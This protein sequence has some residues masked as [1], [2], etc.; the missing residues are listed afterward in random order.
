[1]FT[2]DYSAVMQAARGKA[3]SWSEAV[4]V[5]FVS[6]LGNWTGSILLAT[7]FYGAGFSTGQVGEFISN[8]SAF[9]MNIPIASL[10]L[11]GV[12]CNMLV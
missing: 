3:V 2:E 11:R 12:L 7:L 10:F 1:M 9:K 4:K 5:W 6:Y 8:V